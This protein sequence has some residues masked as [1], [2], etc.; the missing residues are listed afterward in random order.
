M[1]KQPTGSGGEPSSPN[2]E[3]SA[4]VRLVNFSQGF[5]W[6]S[7]SYLSP[8]LQF[9]LHH[10]GVPLCPIQT[11]LMHLWRPSLDCIARCGIYDLSIVAPKD[12]GAR[13]ARKH[14]QYKL[15]KVSLNRSCGWGQRS[16]HPIFVTCQQ[17]CLR[18]VRNQPISNNFWT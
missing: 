14:C 5:L 12:L 10:S 17:G 18:A 16:Q 13:W 8:P 4:E 7:K 1:G 15:H 2:C 9:S 11:S 6:R 3:T